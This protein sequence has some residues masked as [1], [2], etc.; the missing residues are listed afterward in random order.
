MKALPTFLAVITMA[1]FSL[2]YAQAP[3]TSQQR[4][5]ATAWNTMG[6]SID[7]E[8]GLLQE[9]QTSLMENP[10]WRVVDV[11]E[12]H[13][14]KRAKLIDQVIIEHR[15]RIDLLERIKKADQE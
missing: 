7:R 15:K 12:S 11:S 5:I 10:P 1:L 2:T 6:R 4:E 9:L 3:A 8:N 14:K 13:P